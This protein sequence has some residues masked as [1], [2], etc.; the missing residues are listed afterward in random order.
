M[1]LELRA[2]FNKEWEIIRP[3]SL[4]LEPGEVKNVGIA[5]RIEPEF[6]RFDI[7]EIE[8]FVGFYEA[9]KRINL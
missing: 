5:I 8:G 9:P 6:D 4:S 1:D 2:E 7:R 3:Q